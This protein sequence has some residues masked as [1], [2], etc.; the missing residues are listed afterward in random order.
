MKAHGHMDL[1]ETKSYQNDRW[2]KVRKVYA[3]K[4]IYFSG[5]GSCKVNRE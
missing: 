5:A 4:P 3:K 1:R 2:K